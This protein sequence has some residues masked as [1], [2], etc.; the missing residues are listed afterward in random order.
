MTNTE[1]LRIKNFA[2]LKDAEIELSR[3]NVFI[4]PQASGKSVC[5]K[6]L[7]Y[8]KHIIHRMVIA[9]ANE[10]TRPQIK[11]EDRN[12]FL[13]FFPPISWGKGNFLIEY[14]FGE[15]VVTI[16]RKSSEAGTIEIVYSKYYN[17]SFR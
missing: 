11:A 2:G 12:Q 9:V 8:F 4:G 7:F 17:F 1:T 3:M 6:L 14:S 15:F 5:A 13:K 10:R 16:K